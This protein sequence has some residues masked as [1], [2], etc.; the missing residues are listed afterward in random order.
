MHL[1]C[2]TVFVSRA[3]RRR[4]FTIL[5]VM[6]AAAIMAFA[7]SSAIIVMQRALSLQDSA[8]NLTLAG[9]ILQAEFEKMRLKDWTVVGG[10]DAGPTPVAANS[11]F[12]TVAGLGERFTV[13]RQVNTPQADMREIVLTATWRAYDG[14][15]VS[16]S[17]KTHYG[18]FGLYDYYYNNGDSGAGSVEPDKDGSGNN[19]GGGSGQ[20]LDN[21]GG[22]SG[23]GGR[24]DDK[25]DGRD[26]DKGDDKREG[27]DDDRGDTKGDGRSDDKVV[28]KVDDKRDGRGETDGRGDDKDDRRRSDEDDRRRDDD[29]DRDGKHDRDDKGKDKDSGREDRDSR[30]NRKSHGDDSDRRRSDDDER[31]G[32]RDE[33][34]K[35]ERSDRD[36]RGDSDYRRNDPDRRDHE[37]R[38]DDQRGHDRR[39]DKSRDDKSRDDD[40]RDRDRHENDRKDDDQR[41]NDRR[42]DDRRDDDR[43]EDSKLEERIRD[44]RQVGPGPEK[45]ANP[46]VR[47]QRGD[48]KKSDAVET[49]DPGTR[50]SNVASKTDG[51]RSDDSSVDRKDEVPKTESRLLFRIQDLIR[52]VVTLVVE[53]VEH[54][55]SD[56]DSRDTKHSA[57]REAQ[58]KARVDAPEKEQRGRD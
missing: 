50:D 49:V 45:E 56:D 16:H 46:D 10:F 32:K 39:E 31:D 30:W 36:R 21:S 25:D 17:M 28:I 53:A 19:G 51:Q 9:Q 8:R 5:E 58:E 55:R 38:D 14:R 13:Q 57:E 27:R 43:R 20:G 37:R 26:N 40:R 42:D 3:L 6:M 34:S 12:G 18:R 48:L 11:L 1:P 52:A 4:G 35:D 29:D 7:L 15:T 2:E 47:D 54:N 33:R 24:G 44:D 41:D 22:P 23:G